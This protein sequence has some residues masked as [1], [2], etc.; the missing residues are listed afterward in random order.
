MTEVISKDDLEDF[1]KRLKNWRDVDRNSLESLIKRLLTIKLTKEHQS[2]IESIVS[3]VFKEM[4]NSDKAD[5]SLI[6]DLNQ[7]KK[8]IK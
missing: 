5:K 8:K 3:H 7:L 6:G 1:L 2:S 4:I